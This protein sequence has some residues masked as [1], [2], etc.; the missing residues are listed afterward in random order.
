MREYAAFSKS[1]KLF[2]DETSYSAEWKTL[3]IDERWHW[4]VAIETKTVVHVD[5]S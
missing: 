5:V 4:H 2:N 1:G 3:Q